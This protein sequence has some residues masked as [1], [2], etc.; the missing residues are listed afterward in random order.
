MTDH[1]FKT[2]Y[3]VIGEIIAEHCVA[4]P[5]ATGAQGKLFEAL[6][7]LRHVRAPGEHIVI[8]EQVSTAL[9]RLQW[10]IRQRDD[11][12]RERVAEQLRS[13]RQQWL[14]GGGC[15]PS[16]AHPLAS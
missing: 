4:G 10:A 8:A 5:V 2:P 11:A 14:D 15:R 7:E 3:R 13:L 16:A 12:A 6:D 1:T 9:H